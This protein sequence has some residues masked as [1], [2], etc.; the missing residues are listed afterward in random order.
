[1][2]QADAFLIHY[3]IIEE[4]QATVSLAL[5]SLCDDFV[6]SASTFSRRGTW[7]N[8]DKS[9][10]VLALLP[11]YEFDDKVWEILHSN[12]LSEWNQ[13]LKPR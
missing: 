11:Y 9:K 5:M 3:Q 4:Q 7:L 2:V 12:D 10:E 6:A 8:S 13:S 1:M